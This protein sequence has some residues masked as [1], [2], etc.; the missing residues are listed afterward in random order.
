[1]CTYYVGRICRMMLNSEPIVSPT[2]SLAS[3]VQSKICIIKYIEK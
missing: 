1:M 2:D 3:R